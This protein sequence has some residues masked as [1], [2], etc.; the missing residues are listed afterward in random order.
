[1]SFFFLSLFL[2][3]SLCVCGAP[4]TTALIPLFPPLPP[5]PPP[6]KNSRVSYWEPAKWV[7]AVRHA[8]SQDGSAERPITAAAS[9]KRA[10]SPSPSKGGKKAEAAAAA[11]PSSS[12][13]LGEPPALPPLTLLKTDMGAGHFSV[14][15]RFARLKET[16]LEYAFLL[17]V[18]G[19]ARAAPLKGTGTEA[20][21]VVPAD[22]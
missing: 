19:R 14:T 13:S 9:P 17:K 11:P 2:F 12:S 16:A 18:L 7:A 15:G 1:V 20:P 5:P 10:L 21:G 6:N 3:V 4:T 8:R 22:E